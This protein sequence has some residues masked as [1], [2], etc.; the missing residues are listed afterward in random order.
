[1][2]EPAS[3]YAPSRLLPL[4]EADQA[5]AL[6]PELEQAAPAQ[7]AG[8]AVGTEILDWARKAAETTAI[9]E[10]TYMLYRDFQRVG[11][12]NS[13]Q[14]PYYEKRTLLTREALAAW[15][16]QDDSCIGRVC[17]LIWNICEETTWVLPAHERTE[18]T[19]D[20]FSAETGAELAH[21][22]LLLGGALPDEIHERV[23]SEIER[24][25]FTPYMEFAREY[26]WDAG[27]NNWTGV[28]AG[29]VGETFLLLEKARKDAV[30]RSHLLLGQFQAIDQNEHR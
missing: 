16:G 25:I 18:W 13:Y 27:S 22:L 11:D 24:R 7:L 15:L 14:R 3:P 20:L 5:C 6:L 2:S 12:R 21:V 19:I 29:S 8:T 9:P 30:E 26:W 4:L 10:T 17:D 28:C 23:R 1:M